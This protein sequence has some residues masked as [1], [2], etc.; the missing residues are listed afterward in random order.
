MSG[1]ASAEG[2]TFTVTSNATDAYTAS[3]IV[4]RDASGNF[5]AGT[6]TAALTGTASNAA[7]LD[8]LDSTQ[9]LRSDAADTKTS[10]DLSFS[11]NV[12]AVFGAGSDL[13][14]YHD[15]LNS[16]VD[17][18]GSGGLNVRGTNLN[19]TDSA[20]VRFL[21]GE[22]GGPT[23]FYH[24]GTEVLTSTATGVDV[25]GTI[26]F[27]GGTT[28]ADLNFGDNDKAVFGAGSDLQIYHDGTNSI[29]HD[30]GTGFLSIK[31][32]DLYIGDSGGNTYISA[33]DNGVGGTVALYHNTAKKLETTAT[34]VDVTGVITTDGMTTSADINFGDNDKA[35]FGA[36]G[37]L[38]IY[39]DSATG[40]TII[41]EG[42]I[43][44]DL[45]IQANN[46]TLKRSTVSNTEKYLT[47]TAN[48]SVDLYYDGSKKL[49]TTSSGIDVTGTVTADGL[50]V[51]GDISLTGD[52]T[53]STTMDIGP[54]A[55]GAGVNLKRGNGAVNGLSLTS[56][57]D[58]SFYDSLGTTQGLFWDASTQRLGLGTTVP[59]G[60]AH[61]HTA[62]A[63]SVTA[64]TDADDL[65]VENSGNSGISILS[66]DASR[67]AIMFGHASD[68][69]KMQIRHDG[70]TSLSQIISDDAV[71]FNV[72][73]GTERMRINDTGVGIG[74]ASI[75]NKLHLEHAGTL[76]LQ[77]ENTST[78]NKFYLGNSGGNAIL[79][80]TGA[81]SMNFKTN[82]SEAARFDS[83]GNLLINH[84]ATGDWTNTSGAQIRATGLGIF[85]QSASSAV[86]A[87]RLSTDGTILDLRKD[88]TTVG[89]IGVDSSR[90]TIGNG[91]VGLKF[92][93]DLD[94]IQPHNTTTNGL[95]DN[96]I[97][98]GASS[99][100]FK[101]AYFSGTV[102]ADQFLG[103]NDTNTGIAV[104]GGDV[105]QL[106]T[107][108][109]EKAR[110]DASGNLLVG[111]T[112]T[113]VYNNNANSSA[114]NGLNLRGDGKL[115]AARY[116][117]IVLGLNLT[118][119]DGTLAE[120]R[121]SG[122]IAGVIGVRSGNLQI[123][124]DDVGL[125][126]H[127]TDNTIYP[128]NVT[129]QALPN[130]TISFGSA[131]SRFNTVYAK[132]LDVF[133][134]STTADGLKISR[135]TPGNYY[136]TLRQDSHGLAIYVGTGGAVSERVAITPNGITFNGDTAAANALDDYEEGTWVPTIEGS[137]T[138][139][140]GIS[141]GIQDGTY[142]KIGRMVYVM[143]RVSFAFTA[144]TGAGNL[145]I[146]GLPV[147]ST[148]YAQPKSPPQHDNL[149]FTGF[150]YLEMSA[151]SSTATIGLA[152]NRSGSSAS[153][154]TLSDCNAA[155]TDI[156]GGVFY[157]MS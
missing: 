53:S 39:H 74:T 107:G 112:D 104:G 105:I 41:N 71:T 1:S 153:S 120:F 77:I 46:L 108:G 146:A 62:S 155:S 6:I 66:P 36:G 22:S 3:T 111:T 150:E 142:T 109:S 135:Y 106:S 35:V 154:L 118:G 21:R 148:I 147:A 73:G 5:S 126:F 17:E 83:N 115:D 117:G 144:G 24:Q 129:T 100:R 47:G 110:V 95:R 72:I 9:F 78:A 28:S 59:D 79:E 57:G 124:T 4:A 88:G 64:Y 45:V 40:N 97:S 69:L 16:Y 33:I 102:Y 25:T 134:G 91:D 42:N 137:T 93:G 81:Y 123:G 8:S 75:D 80:S 145:V 139:P 29:I 15:G 11:D 27:D 49:A 43:S 89:S 34:G 19:L 96:A 87:N 122:A 56:G 143:F 151:S 38:E 54:N 12:K 90:L 31:A 138:N 37:D 86:I 76:Y 23:R 67:S 99:N 82:G 113:T 149:S 132:Y 50:T 94:N 141:Y 152:K 63:G 61:I 51:D 98:L 13:Q 2:A 121:K 116:N 20:G 133:T 114:D 103:Q 128:A 55:F 30:F 127:D 44:G 157:F 85:T 125:E 156:N 18:Q 119:N 32:T 131:S 26:T 92:S 140:S 48:G 10:G 14:I 58:V 60:T 136:S 84:T 7:L 70:A 65:I 130:G 52:I 68:N 101:D